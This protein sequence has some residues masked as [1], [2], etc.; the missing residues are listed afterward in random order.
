MEDWT[1]P[2]LSLLCTFSPGML[3]HLLFACPLFAPS[4]QILTACYITLRVSQP[5][6][7]S[8]LLQSQNKQTYLALHDLYKFIYQN[9]SLFLI[10]KIDLAEWLTNQSHKPQQQQQATSDSALSINA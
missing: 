9:N 8:K 2:S 6:L 10:P 4:R 5:N 3:E 1:H 7:L